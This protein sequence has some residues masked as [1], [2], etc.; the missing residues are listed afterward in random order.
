MHLPAQLY[1][2]SHARLHLYRSMNVHYV[3]HSETYI[4]RY[5]ADLSADPRH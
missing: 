1:F 4:M 5:R 2:S 3:E